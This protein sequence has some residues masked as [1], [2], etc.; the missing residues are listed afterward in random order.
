MTKRM[1]LK[2]ALFAAWE[3]CIQVDYENY[4]INSER[5]LQASYSA[6]LK[7]RLGRNRRLFIEPKLDIVDGRKRKVFY[8]DLVICNT[9]NVIGVVEL[10]YQ[11]RTRP[12]MAKDLQTLAALAAQGQKA[13]LSIERYRGSATGPEPIA[14]SKDVVFVWGGVHVEMGT[15]AERTALPAGCDPQLA[16]CIFELHAATTSGAKARC[17][18]IPRI[19]RHIRT[20]Q[21]P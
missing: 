9:R 10:K 11:P 6:G 18:S 5:S 19:R 14:F 1:K 15:G 3:E 2:Q 7:N 17:Y 13:V 4:H 21:E 12:R 16:G 20:S 8:P